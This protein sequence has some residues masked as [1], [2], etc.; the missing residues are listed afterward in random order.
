MLAI[1]DDRDVKKTEIELLVINKFKNLGKMA[2]IV[3]GKLSDG[4]ET[5]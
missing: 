1:R 4:I 3:K 2:K 5:K